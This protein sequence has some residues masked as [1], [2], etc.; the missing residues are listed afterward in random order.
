MSMPTVMIVFFFSATTTKPFHYCSGCF[1]N[2]FP[3]VGNNGD[4][5]NVLSLGDNSIFSPVF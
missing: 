1:E 2:V 5:L 3:S 4:T